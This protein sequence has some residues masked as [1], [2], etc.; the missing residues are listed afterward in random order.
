MLLV[1]SNANGQ[2][3]DIVKD[4]IIYGS[5]GMAREVAQLIEDINSTNH[6]WNIKGYIDDYKGETHEMISGYRVLGTAEILKKLDQ[7]VN[8]IIAVSDPESK[9]GIYNKIKQYN[10]EFPVL[11]HPSTSIGKNTVIGEGSIISKDCILSVDVTLGR[12][13]FVNMRSIAG[14]DTVIK[15]YSSCL[16]NCIIS[17]NVTIGEGCLLGS[18]CVIMEKKGIGDGARIGMGSIVNFDVEKGHTVLSRPSKS[19]CFG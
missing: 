12:H 4:I 2:G 17:G 6:I 1:P 13:V 3:G 18:G 5:G 14:H 11:I 8:I 9:K 7:P 15:D 16:L 10:I 19:M